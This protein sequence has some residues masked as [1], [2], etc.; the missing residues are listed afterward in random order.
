MPTDVALM[1]GVRDLILLTDSEARLS[2]IEGY[3]L[4]IE[5]REGLGDG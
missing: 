1:L 2:G 4:R 3:R 5:G